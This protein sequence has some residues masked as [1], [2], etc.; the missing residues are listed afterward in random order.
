MVTDKERTEELLDENP[1]E[2][3]KFEW[4]VVGYYYKQG[5]SEP[6]RM[7][8]QDGV[9]EAE[10]SGHAIVKLATGF[11]LGTTLENTPDWLLVDDDRGITISLKP[12]ED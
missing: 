12:V 9:I 3:R 11:G 6:W 7:E 5:S 4:T 10:S 2:L 8:K 1:S